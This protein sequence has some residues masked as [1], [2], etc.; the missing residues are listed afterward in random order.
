MSSHRSLLGSSSM[1][2]GTRSLALASVLALALIASGGGAAADGPRPLLLAQAQPCPPGPNQAN[3]LRQLQIQQQ[4]QQQRLQQLQAQQRQQQLLQ[5]QRQQQLLQQQ[6]QA[7]KQQQLLQQQKQQQLQAQ[8]QQQLLQQ[9]KQQQLQA[10]KQQQLLQQQRQQQLQAQKQQQLLQ[11]QKQQQLQAQ[12]QQQL[13]Q[14]QKQQQLQAQKQQQLLQQQKQQQLQARKQQQLQSQ[15]QLREQREQQLLQQRQQL[16]AQRQLAQQKRLPTHVQVDR[17]TSIVRRTDQRG[18]TITR[19]L[20]NDRRLV[21]TSQLGS[22][23]RRQ[24]VAYSWK[25]DPATG[26]QTR[27]Y[28]DGR[29]EVIGRDFVMRSGPRQLTVT[30]RRDGLR[31]AFLPNGRRL[32]GDRFGF[33]LWHGRNER[34][35]IRTVATVIIGGAAVALATPIEQFFLIVTYDGIVLRPYIPVVFAAGFYDPFWQ[36]F[37]MPIAIGPACGFCPPPVLDYGAPVAAYADPIDLIADMVLADGIEDAAGEAAAAGPAP[38]DPEVAALSDEVGALQQQIQA[39]EQSNTQLRS[40]L[41]AQQAQIDALKQAQAAAPPVPP[42]K[43]KLRIPRDVHDQVRS[44]VKDDIALHQQQKPLSLTDVIASAQAAKYVF[45]V[46]DLIDATDADTG[47]TCAL[48][49]GDLLTFDQVPAAGEAAAKVRVVAGKA[50][51]CA[52]GAVVTVSL[53]DLQDMLNA[54]SQRVEADMKKVHD[55][56]AAATPK[57]TQ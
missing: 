28:S 7:Q 27:V 13:L 2:A 14:Q 3:C 57:P 50:G 46:A 37:A 1:S 40:E 24:V 42:A 26:T 54:F 8:K 19:N 29:R 36:P 33:H 56:V 39:A 31:E 25:K 55:Q 35:I 48:T 22:N 49:S 30:I 4:L 44:Q 15:R 52:A 53:G 51:S 18:V 6:L 12:K 11:Q 9:Q 5:Q 43:A 41:A 34:V 16:E 23:G 20:G 47:E 10:Q 21:V 45:Q 38:T 17:N 32:F